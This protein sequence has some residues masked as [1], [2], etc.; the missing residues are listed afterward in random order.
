MPK[1][2][3]HEYRLVWRTITNSIDKRTLISTVLPPNV[4]LGNSLNYL[5]PLNFDGENYVHPISYEET[6]FLCGLFNS[7]I[8]DFILRHKI[9]INLNIFQIMELPI[10]KFDKQNILHQKILKNSAMLI[11]TT[12]KYSK[13]RKE[14]GVS[15]YATEPSNRLALESQINA[16]VAKIYELTS[17]ELKLIL[18]IFTIE[19]IHLKE[20]TF[21]EFNL[22][23][24]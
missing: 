19:D 21:D 9:V 16:C 22:L 7:F 13:L 6:I 4:F 18:K 12:D 5:N 14:I 23:N 2:H 15:D 11:C 24:S 17:D 10:P 3:S 8:L 20:L 1:I